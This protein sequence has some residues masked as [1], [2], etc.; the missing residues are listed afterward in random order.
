[1][2]LDGSAL[3]ITIQSPRVLPSH[4]ADILIDASANLVCLPLAG[5]HREQ[6]VYSA[7]LRV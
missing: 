2:F 1:M 5:L 4:G 3:V 7:S 6:N